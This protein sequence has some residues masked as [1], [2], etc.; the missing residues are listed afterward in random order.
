M[1]RRPLLLATLTIAACAAPP[2][3][4]PPPAPAPAAPAP[5][6][7]T[8]VAAPPPSLTAAEPAP[9]PPP[10]AEPAKP[11]L[12]A[13]AYP[14]RIYGRP[15]VDERLIGLLRYGTS[16]TLKSTELARGQNC[17]GGF[18]QIEPRGYVCNNRSVSLDPPQHLVDVAAALAPS[19]GPM[20][21]RYAFSDGAPMYNRIPTAKEQ[22]RREAGMGPTSDRRKPAKHPSSYEGLAQRER[23]EATDPIPPF[24]LDGGKMNEKRRTLVKE[25][26]PP[27][28]MLSFTKAFEVEGR[29]F[30]LSADHSIVPADRVRLFKPSTFHGTRLGEGVELPIAW[31]RKTAKPKWRRAAAGT[32]DKA[33]GEWGAKTFVGLTGA[34]EDSVEGKRGKYLETTERDGTGATIWIHEKDATVVEKAKRR[35]NGVKPDQKWIVVSISH[36]TLVAYEGMKPVFATLMSPGRGGIP[37]KGHDN[38]QDSTTPLGTY[39]ITFKDKLSTMSPDKPG[40]K[41]TNW[42]AD[43]PHTQYFNPPFALHAAFWHDRFGEPTSAGCVNV[44]P[45][46]AETLF[47][48]T[49]PQVPEEWQGATGAGAPENGPRTAVVVRR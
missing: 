1:L 46:D 29:T 47:A 21:Y 39:N 13:R 7:I 34:S 49:D 14:T 35:A 10:P 9:P 22:A 20:P 28:S 42:I 25:I 18:Y 40:D 30:L 16:V 27:R 32:F 45:T 36:G 48:W 6:P 38:V 44:S 26:I 2:L 17:R 12:W 41:R 11:R 24:L 31:M 19:A 3:P 23:V 33:E 8:T 4:L 15:K 43:V 37:I 5:P